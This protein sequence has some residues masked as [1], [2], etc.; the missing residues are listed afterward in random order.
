MDHR[1]PRQWHWHDDDLGTGLRPLRRIPNGSDV[2]QYLRGSQPL[3]KLRNGGQFRN[4]SHILGDIVDS[5]PA[6]I[7][8]SNEGIQASSYISF[9][10]ST[11]TAH[12]HSSTSVPTTACCM[13]SM[14]APS[15][16]PA[17]SRPG[18][19]LF[20]Y[21]PRGVYAQSHQSGQC[22]TTTPSIGSSSTDR[23]R[24]PTCSSADLSWHRVL[25]GVEAAG[26]NSVYALDVTNPAHHI[27]SSAGKRGAVGFHG[28]GHGTGLQHAGDCQHELAAGRCSSATAIT[29]RIKSPF[30]MR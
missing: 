28:C 3:R 2:L 6:Y 1:H 29:A 22:P 14:T 25:V 26:G 27:R 23:R 11:A 20:A 7:G 8:P 16:P 4:R 30:S 12:A 13:P 17:S 9:A 19:E 5:N 21:I 10:A 24:R 18:Q 15:A